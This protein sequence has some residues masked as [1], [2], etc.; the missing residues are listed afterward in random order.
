MVSFFKITARAAELLEFDFHAYNY[1]MCHWT[2]YSSLPMSICVR[3][4]ALLES[5]NS[6]QIQRFDP[7]GGAG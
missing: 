3:D 7:L 2:H 5:R 1:D 4:V 6:N